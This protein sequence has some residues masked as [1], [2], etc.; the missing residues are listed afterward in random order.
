MP[1][2]ISSL[3]DATTS[4]AKMPYNIPP[5]EFRGF[6]MPQRI[7]SLHDATTSKAKMP[8]KI[9]PAELAPHRVLD[10]IYSIFRARDSSRVM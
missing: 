7:S 4:K 3:H 1:Q 6:S 2:R 10:F 9:P 5:A 8:Y